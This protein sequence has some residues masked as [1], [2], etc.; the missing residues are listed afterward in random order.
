VSTTAKKSSTRADRI[1]RFGDRP[2][3]FPNGR[4]RKISTATG[5]YCHATVDLKSHKL[6]EHRSEMVFKV[7]H[8]RLADGMKCPLSGLSPYAALERLDSEREMLGLSRVG[9]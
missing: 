7:H 3:T 9:G 4:T 6:D 1:L 8:D 2:Q 5:P